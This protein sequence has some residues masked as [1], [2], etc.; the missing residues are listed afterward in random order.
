M[1]PFATPRVLEGLTHGLTRPTTTNPHTTHSRAV[2]GL[3]VLLQSQDCSGSLLV[4][5][6][7]QTRSCALH[8]IQ[9]QWCPSIIVQNRLS[10]LVTIGVVQA[11]VPFLLN[12]GICWPF[13]FFNSRCSLE[14]L[15]PTAARLNHIQR[16]IHGRSIQVAFRIPLKNPAENS[17]RIEWCRT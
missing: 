7:I 10:S 9:F 8:L 4:D 3:I 17:R 14:K 12:A 15:R 2:R 11:P 16:S 1:L 5:P 13:A 6:E